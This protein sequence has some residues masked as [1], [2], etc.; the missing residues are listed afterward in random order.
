MTEKDL[1]LTNIGV[2][3]ILQTEDI[4]RTLDPPKKLCP[5]LEA[6]GTV[7]EE[8]NNFVHVTSEVLLVTEQDDHS[9]VIRVCG[10]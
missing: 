5:F 10:G 7:F 9:P 8:L 2:L 3:K 1:Y 6:G 4:K